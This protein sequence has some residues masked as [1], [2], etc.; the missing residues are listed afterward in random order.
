MYGDDIFNGDNTKL[1][2]NVGVDMRMG[3][4]K[5]VYGILAV[6]LLLVL[7]SS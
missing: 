4:I 7:P 1:L 3:F 2:T 6:L 5:K